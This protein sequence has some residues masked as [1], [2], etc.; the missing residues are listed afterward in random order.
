MIIKKPPYAGGFLIV[1]KVM[2]LLSLELLKAELL[3]N[4]EYFV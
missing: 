2:C 1:V 4:L 3:S